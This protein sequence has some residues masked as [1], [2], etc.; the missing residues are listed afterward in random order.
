MARFRQDPAPPGATRVIISVL[1][2]WSAAFVLGP[3]GPARAEEGD[4]RTSFVVPFTL[5]VGVN[6][7]KPGAPTFA[8][9]VQDPVAATPSPTPD[10]DAPASPADGEQ[11]SDG[12]SVVAVGVVVVLMAAVIGAARR[13]RRK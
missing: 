2:I 12:G 5:D 3:A 9:P 11:E 1:V 10:D 8:R 6:G 13:R 4:A 7:E